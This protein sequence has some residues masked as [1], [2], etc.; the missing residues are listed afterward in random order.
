[1]NQMADTFMGIF[2][3]KRVKPKTCRVCK[4]KFIPSR[5]MQ[6]TCSV[7]CSIAEGKKTTAK[8]Q[9]ALKQAE[10][11]ADLAKREKLKTASDYRR[12][13]QQAFNAFIRARDAGR[14]CI[15]CGKIMDWTGNKIDAGH[16]RSTG[17]APHLRFDED[18]C[19]AQDKQC[20]RYGSG[21]AVDYRIGLIKRIG[22]AEVERIEADQA[23]R[24]WTADDYK[25][26]RD[27][28]RAKLR[29]LKRK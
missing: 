26:I 13:A 19:H 21:R 11:K 18:N 7:P 24:K 17:S 20:N 25:K 28:Y 10:K 27:T 15:C 12:E 29:E 22:L 9:R 8:K 4:T 1:M 5:P 23:Q 6:V 14:P 2:G 3:L 16:F